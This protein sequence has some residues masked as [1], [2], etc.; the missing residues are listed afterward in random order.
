MQEVILGYGRA[1]IP[2]EVSNPA[3][4]VCSSVLLK[5]DNGQWVSI[6][7]AKPSGFPE[8]LAVF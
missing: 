8:G 5:G 6:K 7:K 4:A 3:V 2:R 1:V